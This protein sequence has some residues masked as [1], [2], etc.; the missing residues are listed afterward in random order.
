MIHHVEKFFTHHLIA[1]QLNDDAHD[2]LSD[3]E[4]GFLNPVSVRILSKIKEQHPEKIHI[5]LAEDTHML[6]SVFWH[7]IIDNITDLIHEH[8]S[9][10]RTHLKQITILKDKRFFEDLLIP[11][12]KSAHLAQT[13]RDS[14]L[15]FL[16]AFK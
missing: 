6:K 14:A 15:K 3:L 7:E 4:K 8:V 11:L 12:E 9:L 2:W 13:E 5:N 16:E 10:A 1:R